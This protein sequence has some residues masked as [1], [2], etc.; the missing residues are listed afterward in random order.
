KLAGAPTVPSRFLQR[1]A[2]VADTAQ[3]GQVQARGAAY[4]SL[5]RALDQAPA[6]P[7]FRRPE[8]KPPRAAR[9][10]ALTV[11]EIED[12]LR[13][14]YTIYA[15]HVLK[16]MPLDAVDTPPGPRDR[17]TAV[18]AALGDFTESF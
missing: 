6:E 4:L 5:V 13:D 12:W 10:A 8:P 16:L 17:G 1:L 18:H 7:V 14:P 15:K 3:W 2:A 9:P 11:T